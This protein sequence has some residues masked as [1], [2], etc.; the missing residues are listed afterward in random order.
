MLYYYKYEKQE[1][2]YWFTVLFYP[3]SEVYYVKKEQTEK[4]KRKPDP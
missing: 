3:I 1:F 4:T 2:F